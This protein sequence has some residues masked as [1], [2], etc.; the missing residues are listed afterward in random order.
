[1]WCSACGHDNPEEARFCGRCGRLLDGLPPQPSD[2]APQ[3]PASVRSQARARSATPDERDAAGIWQ[4]VVL[5][6]AALLLLLG[7]LTSI[8]GFSILGMPVLLAGLGLGYAAFQPPRRR[9]L[10][11]LVVAF[12]LL[13]ILLAGAAVVFL[14][15]LFFAFA[16]FD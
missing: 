11:R 14:V 15:W 16:G 9:I 7:G 3:K 8:Q 4:R 1:M 5:A 13:V 2:A 10:R 12:A 6:L